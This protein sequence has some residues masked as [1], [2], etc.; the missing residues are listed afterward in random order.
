MWRE[1][2][3]LQQAQAVV[4][5]ADDA[6]VSAVGTGLPGWIATASLA[7]GELVGSDTASGIVDAVDN[8]AVE[9][10]AG[11]VQPVQLVLDTVATV[12]EVAQAFAPALG[13]V[14]RNIPAAGDVVAP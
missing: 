9:A 1:A 5:A 10:G 12:A 6:E 13:N 4:A 8:S 7:A 11:Q 14:R 3:P 2:G